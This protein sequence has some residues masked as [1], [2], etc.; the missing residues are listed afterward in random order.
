MT[1][2]GVHLLLCKLA[3]V[4]CLCVTACCPAIWDYI[5]M[6][7]AEFLGQISYVVLGK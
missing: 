4:E 3:L 7:Q 6:F 2:Y 1:T 5:G